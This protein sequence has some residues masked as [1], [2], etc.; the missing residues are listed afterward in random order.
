[1]VIFGQADSSGQAYSSGRA[2]ALC[3]QWAQALA[4]R[5]GVMIGWTLSLGVGLVSLSAIFTVSGDLK[6]TST[7]SPKAAK[8]SRGLSTALMLSPAS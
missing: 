4:P 6:D 2:L 8:L 7:H 5:R 3:Q 1:M